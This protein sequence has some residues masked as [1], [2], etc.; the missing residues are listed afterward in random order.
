MPTLPTCRFTHAALV[1]KYH[2]RGIRPVLEDVAH[3]LARSGLDVSLE[4]E[5]ALATGMSEYPALSIKEIGQQCDV[6][7]VVGGDV[8]F[9]MAG[10]LKTDFDDE[11]AP[12]IASEFVGTSISS[13]GPSAAPPRMLKRRCAMPVFPAP[14]F[15]RKRG[16]GSEAEFH[17]KESNMHRR[18]FLQTAGAS[19]LAGASGRLFAAPSGGSDARLLLVFLRGGYD[20]LSALSPYTEADYHEA[21]PHVAIVAPAKGR[22]GAAVALDAYWALHPVLVDSL[23]PLYEANQAA[24]VPF[25]GTDFVS[26][27]HFQAQ[28]WV[29]FGQPAGG[30]GIAAG[31]F[32]N[33]LLQ[34]LQRGQAHSD[35]VSFTRA[36]PPVMRGAARVAN[37][38]VSMP[39][40]AAMAP[41]L[42]DRILALYRGHVLEGP[43]RDG[44]GLR[45]QI[46]E[47]LRQEMTYADRGAAP[48]QGF[49]IPL[50][51]SQPDR[52]AGRGMK[53][54]ASPVKQ[55]ALAHGLRVE[56]PAT[57]SLH[58]G[59]PEAAAA[60][61]TIPT[62][63]TITTANSAA[64]SPR[65]ARMRQPRNSSRCSP[66]VIELFSNRSSDC[67]SL[68]SL[69]IGFHG[70]HGRR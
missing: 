34:V 5:T 51:L 25:A 20:A 35:A 43:V 1:G 55:L 38:P 61:T 28:D 32:L 39:R 53:L 48:A 52:A 40:A 54:A 10:D 31:G 63:V 66:K 13:F 18:R 36:L 14:A 68:E 59:G 6:A 33:R 29:E 17:V 3:L 27:S 41:E 37:A 58:R 65:T 19:L 67:R 22:V 49:A 64:A 70:C 15:P 21:R 7:V 26:R 24:F 42:E 46:A 30:S 12:V 11:H 45:R 62:S 69:F 2:A 4:S 50:V 44:I 56:T 9:S 23:L 8:H 57:L 47:E 16:S 60:P